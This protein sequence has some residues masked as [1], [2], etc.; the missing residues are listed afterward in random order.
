MAKRGRKP[1]NQIKWEELNGMWR[2]L[3]ALSLLVIGVIS[4]LA[5]VSGFTS[6][7]GKLNSFLRIYLVE[8]FG[9]LSLIF[10][11]LV[12]YASLVVIGT[13]KFKYLSYKFLIG[14]WIMYLSILGMLGGFA[15]TMGAFIHGKTAGYISSPGAFI[16]YLVILLMTLVILTQKGIDEW[17]HGIFAF[18]QNLIQKVIHIK[19]PVNEEDQKLLPVP[20][21][22]ESENHG[23]NLNSNQQMPLD[24]Q[25]EDTEF[26]SPEP[27]IDFNKKNSLNQKSEIEIVSPP[28]APIDED[29][30]DDLIE[31]DKDYASVT[32]TVAESEKILGVPFSNKVWEYPPISLLSATPN[33]PANA[34]D[35]NERAKRIEETLYSFGIKAKVKDASVG[36]AVTQY[37]ISIPEGSKA[38][39]ISSLATDIALRIKSPS[40]SVRIEAPI[41]GSDLIGI[42]VPN[43]SP[44]TVSLR[45]VLESTVLKASKSK[46]AVPIGLDVSG[47]P[48]VED[49]T[50]WPHALIAGSTGSGKSVMINAIIC[51][52]LFRCTPQELKFIM[53]DPKMVEMIQYK[54]IPHLLTPVITDVEQKAVSALAWAVSEMERRYKAF[55]NAG[56]KDIA[57]YNSKSG[58]QAE[59]YILIIIDELADMMMVAS[60]DVERY[61]T[62]LAQKARATGIH[63]I[64][65]TQRPSVNV[66]TGT[67]KANIP[68]RLSFRVTS[69]VDSRVIIDQSGAETLIGRGDMLFVPP[70]DSKPKRI[71]GIYVSDN[72][73]NALA[74]YLRG[75]GVAPNYQEEIVEQKVG[76]LSSF[77]G[78]GCS[79]DGLEDTKML[80]AIQIAIQENKASASYLQRKLSLGYSRA[81]RMVD[82]MEAAGIIGPQNGSKPREVYVASIDEAVERLKEMYGAK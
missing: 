40:G 3:L 30:K 23:I 11:I 29:A 74:D 17:I 2:S 71:Q 65:S 76:S 4:L 34:G 61:I 70:T 43:Y 51:S 25:V 10:P 24:A 69:N 37:A 72:E 80:D 59:P 19:P 66:L 38:N 63:L 13:I 8:A 52:L 5:I 56:V 21:L 28:S 26:L 82:D 75:T 58:F 67:I 50:R 81:A 20:A 68:T 45:S 62:R 55:S 48:I 31:E 54:D 46:L 22:A 64:I 18:I 39:K 42:E 7:S 32:A 1:K 9:F 33:Q 14:L 15:G 27:Q 73:I 41:P 47:K 49:I 77:S 12:I 79:T 60:S 44:S 6:E 78:G 36:P 35:V 57:S 16:L 53:I